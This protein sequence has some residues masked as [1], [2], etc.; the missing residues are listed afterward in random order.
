MN[1]KEYISVSPWLRNKAWC[2]KC[3]HARHSAHNLVI[4]HLT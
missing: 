3:L 2:D 4:E 1:S